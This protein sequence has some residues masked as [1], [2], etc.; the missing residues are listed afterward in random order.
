M[1]KTLSTDT[2]NQAL[3]ESNDKSISLKG[4]LDQ[5]SIKTNFKNVLEDK[6]EA[7][8]SNLL[9]VYNLNTS[10]HQ[11][12]PNSIITSALRSATLDLPIDPN[13]G[14]AHLVP[15][16]TKVGKD[17]IKKAQ[18]QIGWKGFVQLAIRTQLFKT[19]NVTEVFEGE[20]QY[21]NRFTGEMH[22]DAKG[23]KSEEIIGY[24]SYFKLL[25]G[26]EKFLYMT[27]DELEKHAKKYSQSYKQG[28]G[29]WVDDKDGMSKKTVVKLNLS[30]YAPLTTKMKEAIKSDQSIIEEDE[31]GDI[32]YNYEDNN[33]NIPEAEEIKESS[34]IPDTKI[35]MQQ[36]LALEKLCAVCKKTDAQ[37]LMHLK[38]F[39]G[40]TK[41]EDIQLE[42]YESIC[43]WIKL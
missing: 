12:E 41:K 28:Y 2:L 31:K 32:K 8:M 5:D 4:L 21:H 6:A 20:I 39:Y 42:W 16:R 11:C 18:F 27:T 15:Y 43:E 17:W 30:K 23:K 37:L 25:N 3:Q 33:E 40:T 22:F 26:F 7:F 35:S 10:L 38:E 36:Q 34:T 1:P 24:V 14:F 9:V 29:N 19:I 13:L